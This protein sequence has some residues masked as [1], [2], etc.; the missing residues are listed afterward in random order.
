V[1]VN[2]RQIGGSHYR[3]DVKHQHWD[4]VYDIFGGDYLIGNATKYLARL[5]KKGGPDKAL[6]DINKAIHYLEKKREKIIEEMGSQ[7]KVSGVPYTMP[8]E[9]IT[10]ARHPYVNISERNQ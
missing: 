6:E 9:A 8:V 2:D 1:S 7:V 5:G 4:I 10:G 3:S